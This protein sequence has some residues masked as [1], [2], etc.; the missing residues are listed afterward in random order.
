MCLWRA[1]ADLSS[2]PGEWSYTDILLLSV[3]AAKNDLKLGMQ[4]HIDTQTIMITIC[5]KMLNS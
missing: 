4:K 2:A 3:S 5:I 1:L